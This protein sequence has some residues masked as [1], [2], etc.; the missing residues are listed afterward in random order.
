MSSYVKNNKRRG[1]LFAIASIVF[2]LAASAALICGLSIINLTSLHSSAESAKD[3]GYDIYFIEGQQVTPYEFHM[4]LSEYTSEYSYEIDPESDEVTLDINPE[5]TELPYGISSIQEIEDGFSIQHIRPDFSFDENLYEKYMGILWIIIIIAAIL[6]PL[7]F[8]IAIKN[9]GQRNEDGSIRMN[10]FDKVFT[11]IQLAAAAAITLGIIPVYILLETWFASSEWIKPLVVEL[12]NDYPDLWNMLSWMDAREW[13]GTYYTSF[14]QP[15]WVL[16]L[17]SIVCSIVIFAFDILIASSIAKKIK[18]RRF[19]RGTIIGSL[20][21]KATSLVERNNAVSGKVYLPVIGFAIVAALL[22]FMG[23][24][25]LVGNAWIAFWILLIL[26]VILISATIAI[27]KKQVG[28]YK[29]VKDGLN[30]V[31]KG[32]FSYKIPDLGSGEFGRLA[33]SVNSITDAQNEAI[34]NELKSQRLR[35]ELISNVSHDL[36]TPLTSMVSYVDL[37]KTEGLGSPNAE[38]YLE[39]ISEKTERLKNLTDNLFEAAKASSGDIPVN[40]ERIDL[41]AIARQAIAELEENIASNNVELVYNCRVDKPEVMAD[42]NLLWRVIEN[43]ITNLS[44]YA[45][46]GTRAYV[47]I[48][49]KP[50]ISIGNNVDGKMPKPLSADGVLGKGRIALEV[51]N[52]SREALNISAEELMERFQRGDDSRNTDGSGLGLAIA[53][54]LTSLMNGTFEIYVDGDLFKATVE[55]NRAPLN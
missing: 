6:M 55:L 2:V 10:W 43:L 37:L 3:Y 48:V 44:K 22:G 21:Y 19:W 7:S 51:K 42:G 29:M 13:H 25:A 12:F 52:M 15:T 18:A 54:D 32:N 17:L 34:R 45:L 9:C 5:G 49:E 1:V 41:D 16:L 39:I 46:P 28:K 33:E 24:A 47:D 27:L 31:Q 53:N 20:F 30:E 35:S 36:R 8:I 23:C 4:S 14:F 40:I 26:G 38:E 50:E 11:E